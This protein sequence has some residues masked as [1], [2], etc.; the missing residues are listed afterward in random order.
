MARRMLALADGATRA[1]YVSHVLRTR[2]A[3]QVAELLLVARSGAEARQRAHVRLLQAV[4]LGLAQEA[5]STLRDAVRDALVARGQEEAARSLY[6]P[7]EEPEDE[8]AARVPDFGKG[9]TLALGER[10]AL[11]R[12]NDRALI[13]KVLRDPHPD[14]IRIL[15]GN[16][17][18]TETDVVLLCARRPGATDVLRE[19][20]RSL[21]WIAHERVRVALAL[22]PWTPVDIALQVAPLLRAPDLR[23]AL[24]A[25]DLAPEMHAAC[26]RLLDGGAAS[27]LH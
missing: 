20:F 18:L 27:P 1:A 3:A 21:R 14:V 23:R 6:R 13:A 15:L 9:R 4:T 5:L 7:E 12:R 2:D 26:R 24:R 19:V 8:D 16:P 25:A 17:G 10:K 11:A 22:N